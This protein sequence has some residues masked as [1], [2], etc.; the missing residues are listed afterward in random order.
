[1]GKH[2]FFGKGWISKLEKP[3][4][5]QIIPLFKF[6]RNLSLIVTFEYSF[7]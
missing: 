3:H 1:M 7:Q 4:F 5:G 6:L 2:L